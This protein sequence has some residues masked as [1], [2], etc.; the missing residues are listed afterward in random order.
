MLMI[1]RFARPNGARLFKYRPILPF[2]TRAF[3]PW[4]LRAVGKLI[5]MDAL[6]QHFNLV[7]TITLA[8]TGIWEEKKRSHAI[9]E[10][11]FNSEMAQGHDIL[12]ILRTSIFTF[13]VRHTISPALVN[14]N[15]K[16]AQE[17]RIPDDEL[18][19]QINTFL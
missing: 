16:A 15:S 6:Q 1:M 2:L 5:P 9:G 3:P 4:L 14:E 10:K 12:S 7:D 8:A 19:G 11:A 18:L 13:G 17:D